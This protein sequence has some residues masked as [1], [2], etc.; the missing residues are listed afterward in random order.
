[1]EKL[2]IDKHP[3]LFGRCISDEEKK[4][5]NIDT[6]LFG[7]CISDEQQCFLTMTQAYFASALVMM[8]KFS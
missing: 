7:R 5:Y 2:G 8:Q 1:L 4:F 6:S 3:S